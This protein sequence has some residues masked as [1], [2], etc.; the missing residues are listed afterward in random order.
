[1]NEKINESKH[2]TNRMLMAPGVEGQ[3]HDGDVMVPME[4]ENFLLF[5]HQEES[6]AKLDKFGK[7]EQRAPERGPI[8]IYSRVTY[9]RRY[10]DMS[11]RTS[12][13]SINVR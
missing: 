8:R 4:E 3:Q 5:D 7:C 11:A 1:M 10:R 12:F 6:V 13:H 2:A 9:R